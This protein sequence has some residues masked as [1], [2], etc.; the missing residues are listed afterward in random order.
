[1]QNS[2][3]G[4]SVNALASL[5]IPYEFPLSL[6][7]SLRGVDPDTTEENQGMGKITIPVLD[8]L[9]I[10]SRQI[11]PG[12]VQEDLNWFHQ[13]TSTDPAR[14]AALL[15]EPTFFGWNPRT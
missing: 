1:M 3:L 4:Q 9:G 15:I 7:I 8:G 14:A 11:M 12:S 6:I 10:Q 13:V 2:G 5:V